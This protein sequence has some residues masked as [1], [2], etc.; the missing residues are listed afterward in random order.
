[1]RHSITALDH[2]TYDGAMADISTDPIAEPTVDPISDRIPD[3]IVDVVA[4]W[5]QYVRGEL[6]DGL[7]DLLDDD[8]VFYSP[9]VFTPQRGKDVTK[10]YLQAA[11]STLGGQTGDSDD[12]GSDGS[13]PEGGGFRYVR[14][15]AQ[16]HTAL[17]EFETTLDG[18]YVNGIDLF[19]C[20]DEGRIVEFKVLIRP[21]QAINAVHAAMR[22]MIESM[23]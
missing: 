7:D 9:V 4:R 8:V 23:A 11:G 20:N 5:H 3:P 13:G 15:L 12:A 19:M 16:G 21:L 1:M 17:L 18:K 2:G 10:L 6:P 14:E 22:A